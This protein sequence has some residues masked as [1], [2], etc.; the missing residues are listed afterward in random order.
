MVYTPH[1]DRLYE[2]EL[3][4][5]SARVSKMADHAE[6]MVRDAMLALLS[7]N[8]RLASDVIAADQ[9]LDEMEL[10]CDRACVELLARRSPV[11]ADLRFV[12]GVLKLVTDIERIGDLAVNVVKRAG[13]L[14]ELGPLPPEIGDLAH[15]VID[16]LD[17]AFKAL[18]NR[19]ASLARTLRA[20]DQSTDAKN[21]AAFDRLLMTASDAHG[22]FANLLTL[23]NICRHLERIGDHAVNIAEIVV[24]MVE[25][26]VLRHQAG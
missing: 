17:T 10:A 2:H 6:Q 22:Q 19:D 11:G 14:A 13:Q 15:S 3:R 5:V 18:K 16:E 9:L 8:S 7:S 26:K 20:T 21:R 24:Y 12:T 25:G 4:E 23:T 1:L